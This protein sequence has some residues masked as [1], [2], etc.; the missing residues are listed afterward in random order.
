L[1]LAKGRQEELLALYRR[2]VVLG[3]TDVERAL[4][5]VQ[6][7][8][9]REFLQQQV[10]DSSRRAFEIA[11]TRLREGTVDLIT[12]LVTQQAL[13]TAEE[14]RVTAR[15]ARLQAVLSL[16]QAL[17]GSWLP[18]APEPRASTRKR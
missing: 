1:D 10:V 5:S 18:R 8:T 7:T 14:N 4:I 13:F 17:G 15:L 6:E 9:Q 16:Y 3:F 12:V 2:A 11:E